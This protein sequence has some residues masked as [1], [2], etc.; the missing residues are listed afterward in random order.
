MLRRGIALA[1]LAPAIGVPA[2]A[3]ATTPGLTAVRDQSGA[4]QLVF[5]PAAGTRYRSVAGR[6]IAVRCLRAPRAEAPIASG[7][8]EIFRGRAPKRRASF[9]IGLPAWAD[10]CVVVRSGTEVA[11]AAVTEAGRTMVLRRPVA[12]RVRSQRVSLDSAGR[13]AADQEDSYAGKVVVLPGPDSPA[14]PWPNI[15]VWGTAR[16]VLVRALAA[17]GT[18]VER[19]EDGANLQTNAGTWSLWPSTAVAPLPPEPVATAHGFSVR[20]GAVHFTRRG[21]QIADRTLDRGVFITCAEVGDPRPF[22]LGGFDVFANGLPDSAATWVADLPYPADVCSASSFHAVP[23]EP[24]SGCAMSLRCGA[25]VDR[26]LA[27]FAVTPAGHTYLVR[28]AAA[29]RIENLERAAVTR[30]RDG[31]GR[32]P[33]TATLLTL[34][35]QPAA[36]LPGP[37]APAPSDGTLAVWGDGAGRMV[38]RARARD[39]HEFWQQHDGDVVSANTAYW[40]YDPR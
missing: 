23:A 7:Y 16:T 15:G 11:S 17:D 29:R 40:L 33:D 22:R 9:A 19:I 38:L 5:G 39:G 1:L 6:H 37:G 18:K 24:S 20:D 4:R 27:L 2:S 21:S 30:A 34:A 13:P 36:A 35:D 12:W 3:K 32:L 8:R 31:E 14:P 28:R 10:A 26:L 25:V